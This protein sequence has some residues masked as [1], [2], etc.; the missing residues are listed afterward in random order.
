MAEILQFT[1]KNKTDAAQNAEDFVTLCRDHLS[2]FG[3]DLAWDDRAWD[4]SDAIEKRGRNGRL[5]FAWTNFD[6]S[7][8]NKNAPLMAEPFL[9]FA[10]SYMRYQHS[11]RPTKGFGNR[12]AALRALE[13]ALTE[14]Y[15]GQAPDITNANA[16]VFNSAQALIKNKSETSTAYREACQLEMISKFINEHSLVPVKFQWKQSLNRNNDRNRIGAEGDRERLDKL[17]SKEAIEALAKAF[18]IAKEPNDIIIASTAALLACAPSRINEIFRLPVDCE[19]EKEQPDGT[20]AYGLRWWPSKGAEPYVKWIGPTM[21]DV[22][23]EAISN[24]RE[25]TS[26]ARSVARWYQSNPNSMWLPRDCELLRTQPISKLKD[27][28]PALELKSL[29]SVSQWMK[30]NKVSITEL[31]GEK[32][33]IFKDVESAVLRLLPKKFPIYD[34]E[35]DL[36]FADALMVTSRN[37]FHSKKTTI[38]CIVE[39]INE[40]HISDGL[41]GRALQGASSIFSR[42]GFK[43]NDGSDIVINTHSFRHWL[44]TI[45]Q[46]G[47]LSELDIAIW[48]GRKDIKQNRVYNHV[49]PDEMLAI[50]NK[51]IGTPN[52]MGP[53][54]EAFEKLPVSREDFLQMKF[55]TAHTTEFGFCI[56]DFTMLPCQKHRDCINCTEQVCIKGDKAKTARIRSAFEIVSEQVEKARSAIKDQAFGADRWL[57]VHEKSA[58]RLQELLV[59]MEDPTIPNGAVIQLANPDEYSPINN[60]INERKRL[61]DDDANILSS[62]RILA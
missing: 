58:Q 46:R 27:F 40:Q 18:H 14:A 2:V 26:H 36:H 12:L 43:N 3:K 21:V 53:L 39:P 50:I 29:P 60:A 44:N 47:G 24:L 23:K 52:M 45:A 62:F 61:S 19:V 31:N 1:P 16:F 49:T 33:V 51:E 48:S 20:I 25:A 10:R 5:A 38:P 59:I 4:V 13:R 34:V 56:H 37:L 11:M 41:G 42:L 6:T 35:T 30:T 9:S 22:A 28:L 55:P 17:P 32:H 57:E 7:K 54:A 15:K 8:K